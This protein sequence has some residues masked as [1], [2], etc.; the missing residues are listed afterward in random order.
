MLTELA[1]GRSNAHRCVVDMVLC[2]STGASAFS[3]IP[4]IVGVADGWPRLAAF[5]RAKA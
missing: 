4:A 5:A 3:L 1:A 2:R